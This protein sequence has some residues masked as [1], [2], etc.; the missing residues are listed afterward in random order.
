MWLPPGDSTDRQALILLAIVHRLETLLPAIWYAA[1]ALS[2]L[3][4]P[5]HRSELAV[6]P[7]CAPPFAPPCEGMQDTPWPEP[8]IEYTSLRCARHWRCNL[9]PWPSPFCN[10]P[11]TARWSR[12]HSAHLP[13]ELRPAAWR[14]PPREIAE[15]RNA[16]AP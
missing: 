15:M 6:S 14:S 4:Y 13:R 3:E 9:L 11:S 1:P 8:L 16:L 10:D 7:P 12:R 2:H 5:G